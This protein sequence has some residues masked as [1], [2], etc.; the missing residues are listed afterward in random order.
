MGDDEPE[1][2]LDMVRTK[3]LSAKKIKTLSS[4]LT[5]SG[6]KYLGARELLSFQLPRK[7]HNPPSLCSL[8]WGPSPFSWELCK[9]LHDLNIALGQLHLD[10]L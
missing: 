2:S 4:L 9:L 6:V 3:T 1:W 7:L 10:A 8:G 5:I